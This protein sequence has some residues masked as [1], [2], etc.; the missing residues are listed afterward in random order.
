MKHGIS[1]L[2]WANFLC[3][4]CIIVNL[5]EDDK[6]FAVA[7]FVIALINLDDKGI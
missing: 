5:L 1:F 3:M 7:K 4:I 2:A 6:V